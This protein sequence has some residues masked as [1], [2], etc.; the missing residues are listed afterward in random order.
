MDIS[1]AL[2]DFH[3]NYVSKLMNNIE[4]CAMYFTHNIADECEAVFD[5]VNYESTPNFCVLLLN[6]FIYDIIKI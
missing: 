6:P 2:N 5:Y 3:L 1:K 4:Q